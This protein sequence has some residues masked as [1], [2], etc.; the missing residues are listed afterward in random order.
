MIN[1]MTPNQFE[2]ATRR[3]RQRMFQMGLMMCLVMLMLDAHSTRPIA[4][5]KDP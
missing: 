2:E 3:Q 1:G 5:S 4:A